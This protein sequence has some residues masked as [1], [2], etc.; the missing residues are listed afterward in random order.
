[1]REDWEA[2][3]PRKSSSCTLSLKDFS[4]E[5]DGELSICCRRRP[6]SLAALNDSEELFP[7]SSHPRG[8]NFRV[9]RT[10]VEDHGEAKANGGPS[11]RRRRARQQAGTSSCLFPG[12][13]N[14]STNTSSI[15]ARRRPDWDGGLPAHPLPSIIR[16]RCSGDRTWKGPAHQPT[17]EGDPLLLAIILLA[18]DAE[19]IISPI[20]RTHTG[21]EQL[22]Y[23][24]DKA[25]NLDL[26]QV[27]KTKS[28]EPLFIATRMPSHP[29]G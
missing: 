20:G 28:W 10:G 9:R 14:G 13:G 5:D 19:R 8:I 16:A 18:S 6:N 21:W 22:H 12:P 11:G 26:G 23:A 1:V 17:P 15:L 2:H 4:A 27:W 3:L 29:T 7:D 24:K 25:H